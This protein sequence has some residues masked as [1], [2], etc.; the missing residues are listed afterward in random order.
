MSKRVQRLAGTAAVAAIAALLIWQPA[1]ARGFHARGA[2]GACGGWAHQGAYGKTAGFGGFKRG[3]GGAWGS[4]TSLA[5]AGGST[6]KGWHA[7]KYNAQ[8]GQG[9]WGSGKQ[10]YN[11][12]TGNSYGY[13]GDTTYQKGQGGTTAIDTLNHGDYTVDWAKGQKPVVTQGQ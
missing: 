1:E 4:G 5:G 12:K 3:V 9:H 7:G 11:A 6:Y 10:L 13:T 8:T 2:N